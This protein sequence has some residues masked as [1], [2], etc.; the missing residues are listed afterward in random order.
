MT[1]N[2][3]KLTKSIF[4]DKIS[5]KIYA[6]FWV[7]FFSHI[8]E[9]FSLVG[10]LILIAPTIAIIYFAVFATTGIQ[11]HHNII[12]LTELVFS[13]KNTNVNI[14]C[15]VFFALYV[16]FFISSGHQATMGQKTM[17]IYVG[18]EAGR[19]TLLVWSII[20]FSTNYLPIIMPIIIW[21]II[22]SS[23]E[24]SLFYIILAVG[25]LAF[26]VISLLMIVFTK[27]K[28]SLPDLICGT[29]VFYGKK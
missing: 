14:L 23:S 15:F 3:S 7:R 22:D 19:K 10:S 28:I 29:R 12:G 18:D 13:G 26:L 16:I 11:I 1:L 9:V 20:R 21:M 6:G 24:N 8:V 27:H 25:S 4:E 17:S 2:N 5:N